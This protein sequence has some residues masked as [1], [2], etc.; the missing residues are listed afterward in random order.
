MLNVSATPPPVTLM[1][2]LCWQPVHLVSMETAVTRA[3]AAATTAPATR[4][5]ASVRARR[6]GLDPRAQM[7]R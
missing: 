6:A 5:V 4:P 1:T 7:V 3:V 2:C